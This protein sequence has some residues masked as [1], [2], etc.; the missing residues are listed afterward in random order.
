MDNKDLPALYEASNKISQDAQREFFFVFGLNLLCLSLAAVLSVFYV[1]DT[2]FIYIQIAVLLLSFGCTILIGVRLPEKSWYGGRALAESVKTLSW[3]FMVKAEPFNIDSDAAIE[4][5][6][7]KLKKIVDS[8][9]EITKKSVKHSEGKEIT[10]LM[11][12]TRMKNLNE[13]KDFY[14]KYRINN[15]LTWYRAKSKFNKKQSNIFF[16]AICIFSIF[17]IASSI[18]RI[19]HPTT[20]HWPTDI[21][22]AVIASLLGWNQAKKFRELSAS[23]A[24]TV[25]E[26]NLIKEQAILIKTE[27]NF[28][29]F[30]GDAENGF[31]REHTQWI[32]RRDI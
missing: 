15:Q 32:A 22:V 4:L 6:I 8:N 2:T 3:R 24:Q 26:I 11:L 12:E 14:L 19:N 9:K 17:A 25:Y 1:S 31:S 18:A 13:R 30:V 10:N 23:Y 5:F 20:E 16:I 29:V 28:S 27:E 21:F 7:T